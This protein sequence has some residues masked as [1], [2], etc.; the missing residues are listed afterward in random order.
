MAD[1]D[2]MS[3]LNYLKAKATICDRI[4]MTLLIFAFAG[5]VNKL[6]NHEDIILNWQSWLMMFIGVMQFMS[7]ILF[8]KYEK[9]GE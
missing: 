5:N 3:E 8:A 7:G 1:G 9:G 2:E 4:L 6:I